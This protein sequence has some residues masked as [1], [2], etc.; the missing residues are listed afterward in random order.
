MRQSP[1]A[2]TLAAALVIPGLGGCGGR[3]GA[4]GPAWPKSAGWDIPDDWKDDGGESIAP[5]TGHVA[6][7]ETSADAPPEVTEAPADDEIVIEEPELVPDPDEP[8]PDDPTLYD[9]SSDET[10]IIEG[11]LPPEAP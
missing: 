8:P 2:V 6:A 9:F 11:E 3:A 4:D 1:I 7:V 5:A 10:I